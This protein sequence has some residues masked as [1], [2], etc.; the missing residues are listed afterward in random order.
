MSQKE[1]T[2]I[3]NYGEL[4]KD[5]LY[6]QFKGDRSPDLLK[7]IDAFSLPIDELEGVLKSLDTELNL[8]DAVGAQLDGLGQIIGLPR[9]GLNDHDYRMALK[10]KIQL[11]KSFGQPE[12]LISALQFFT[13]ATEVRLY[14]TFPAAMFAFT[15]GTEGLAHLTERMNRLSLGGV[16]F[17]YVA[18]TTGVPFT[19]ASETTEDFGGG[20]AWDTGSGI[21]DTNAGEYSW[22]LP[23]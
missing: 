17:M 20:Y 6:S 4:T 13:G 14:E 21:Y 5:L 10:F 7:V 11:N 9:N 3:D 22:A 2:Y 1:I 18:Q 23:N 8:D 12:L 19:F 16:D 15:N